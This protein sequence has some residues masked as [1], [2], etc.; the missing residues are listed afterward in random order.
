M[1]NSCTF[2]EE[3]I[4]NW[5]YLL[6]LIFFFAFTYTYS[7]YVYFVSFFFQKNIVWTFSLHFLRRRA[8]ETILHIPT[9]T[10]NDAKL[11]PLS[12]SLSPSMCHILFLLCIA[13]LSITTTT[14]YNNSARVKQRGVWARCKEKNERISTKQKK[15]VIP[16]M[17][18]NLRKRTFFVTH[19]LCCVSWNLFYQFLSRFYYFEEERVKTAITRA[20]VSSSSK[21]L[22]YFDFIGTQK[23]THVKYNMPSSVWFVI[24][25]T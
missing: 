13:T 11:S 14:I 18:C 20:A 3:I 9:Q 7:S 2:H 22:V 5:S 8:Y 21:T 15:F 16:K 19:V 6:L 4:I 10:C 1:K 23:R 12:F 24:Y 17:H 25:S